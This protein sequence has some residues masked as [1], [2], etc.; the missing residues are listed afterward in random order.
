[1][2]KSAI[3]SKTFAVILCLLMVVS[4]LPIATFAAK[5]PMPTGMTK[6]SDEE[7]TLAPGITQNEVAFTDQVAAAEAN[8]AG[9]NYKVVAGI[10]AAFFNTST[11][12]PGGAFAINGEVHC[13]DAEG[14]RYPF[15]AILKDGTAVIDQK[16]T[17]TTYKDRVA[18][19]V[20][21]YSLER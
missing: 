1:M 19:A 3:L 14:N 6:I 8:H 20:Q 16:N 5:V 7:Q 9:E 2:K 17:W 11:G 4:I 21:G 15:F 12:Q 18:E 13:S 10:N